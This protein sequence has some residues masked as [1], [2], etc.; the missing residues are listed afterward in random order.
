MEKLFWDSCVFNALLYD[1]TTSYDVDSIQQYLDEARDGKYVIYTSSVFLAEIAHSKIKKI[2]VG[3]PNEFLNDL[4]GVVVV[5]DASLEIME[6]AGRLKDIPYRKQDSTKRRLGTGD[7]V[8]LATALN[9]QDAYEVEI[10]RFHTFDNG[11]QK[12][13][14]PLLSYE[15]WLEGVIGKKLELAKRV[16]GL[17]RCKPIHPAPTMGGMPRAKKP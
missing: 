14:V 17:K 11:G 13:S 1:E 3:G 9:L 6:L 7:A 12:G 2:G 4:Q 16:S 8:M 5:I 15:Q 10:D